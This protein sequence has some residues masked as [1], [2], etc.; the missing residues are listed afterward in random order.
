[1]SNTL[2]PSVIVVTPQTTTLDETSFETISQTLSASTT[3]TT[4]FVSTF[5]TTTATVTATTVPTDGI[6]V[7]TTLEIL[8]FVTIVILI[9][10][11]GGVTIL[12]KRVQKQI[13]TEKNLR[14][15][16]KTIIQSTDE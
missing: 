13:D 5:I 3:T 12:Y 2:T 1:M 15:I 16:G 7:N 11:I 4:G 9:V 10:I 14:Q 8:A 6:F